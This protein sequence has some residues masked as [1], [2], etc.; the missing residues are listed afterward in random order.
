MSGA[1]IN[2]VGEVILVD[3]VLKLGLVLLVAWGLW[4]ACRPRSSFVVRIDAGVPRV[5]RGKV[6]NAFVQE[7]GEVC[8]R[9]GVSRGTVRGIAKGCRIALVFSGRVPEPCRQQLRNIWNLSGWSAP[10]GRPG[11]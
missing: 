1:S 7:I 3:V 9:H 10:A 8:N 6:T 4:T 2:T 5:A 11:R